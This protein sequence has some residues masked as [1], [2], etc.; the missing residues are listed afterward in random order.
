MSNLT[1]KDDKSGNWI[2]DRSLKNAYK[3]LAKPLMVL[4]ILKK[5]VAYV[6]KYDSIK[7]LTADVKMKI[8]NMSRMIAAFVKGEYTQIS[9]WNIA[10]S[11]A[12]M[13]YLIL[14]L[15]LVP[16]FLF[17]GLLDDIA[18]VGWLYNR[19]QSEIQEFLEWE[20]EQKIQLKV[21]PIVEEESKGEES[22]S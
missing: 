22:S 4:N 8:D 13:M 7:E 5:T 10:L 1:K 20:D 17:M 19:L 16:D 18:V 14:P 2:F 3:L 9:K 11:L 12:A 21:V 15:D 6:K